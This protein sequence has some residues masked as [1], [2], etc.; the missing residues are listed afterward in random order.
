MNLKVVLGNLSGG[1]LE[2]GYISVFSPTISS[3]GV[4]N[5]TIARLGSGRPVI[6][7]HGYPDNLQ[8]WSEVAIRL[9]DQ[10]EVIA[11]D[12][13]GM[14]NSDDWSGGTTPFHMADRLK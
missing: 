9:A 6:L 1:A 2:A 14:G 11:F 3:A 7:L 10:F 5:Y 12:W 4:F 13:P 8:I